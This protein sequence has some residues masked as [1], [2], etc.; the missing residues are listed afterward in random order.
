MTGARLVWHQF[1]YDQRTFWREPTAVFF[2]V[3]LP[4]TFLVIFASIF[5]NEPALFHGRLIRG[6]TYYVPG[7]V[8]LG[9][10]TATFVN[11]AISLVI[12]RERGILKRIRGTPL[13]TWVYLGGR[14]LT[15]IVVALL[16]TSVLVLIG[17]FAYGVGVPTATLP[18][19]LLA[20]VLGAATFCALGFAMAGAI[21]SESAGPPLTNAV[22]LPLFFISGLFVQSGDTPEAMRRVA[23]VFPVKPLFEALLTA[24]DPATPGPGI[25]GREL[26]VVAL[27]GVGAVLVALRTFRW[28]PR[29]E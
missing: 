17:R 16:L 5:G 18:G 29:G 11:I 28:T 7:I 15:S 3:V 21:P 19:A 14:V 4:V 27:W 9:L 24:F 26:A 23:D 2:T 25:A 8:T 6:T 10:V 12:A 22:C 1:R 20:L 13:P